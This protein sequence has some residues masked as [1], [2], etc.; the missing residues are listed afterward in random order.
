MKTADRAASVFLRAVIVR[1]KELGFSQS[2]LAQRMKA[3]R[4]YVT[5]VLNGDISVSFRTATRFAKALQMDFI[6]VL[7]PKTEGMAVESLQPAV[8]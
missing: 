4:P 8:A 7:T 2:V 5:K 6:P 3:S 1:M